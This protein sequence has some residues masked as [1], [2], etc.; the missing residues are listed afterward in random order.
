MKRKKIWD[1]V[2]ILALIIAFVLTISGL[3]NLDRTNAEIDDATTRIKLS[4]VSTGE[5]ENETRWTRHED[6]SWYYIYNDEYNNESIVDSANPIE[7]NRID[8]STLVVNAYE[9]NL[10]DPS[11]FAKGY[12]WL[13]WPEKLQDYFDKNN[14]DINTKLGFVNGL[15]SDS[16]AIL[17]P[18]GDDRRKNKDGTYEQLFAF[19]GRFYV[20]RIDLRRFPFM[21][22]NL[23]IIVAPRDLGDSQYDFS[24]L[25]F[26]PLYDKSGI[27]NYTK[28]RGWKTIDWAISEYKQTLNTNLLE[29]GANQDNHSQVIFS[30]TYQTGAYRSFWKLMLPLLIVMSMV[31]LTFK[32]HPEFQDGRI[33]LLVTLL[34]TL[35]VLQEG[36][37]AELPKL[38][39]LSYLDKIYIFSFAATLVSF[40]GVI[41]GA[42]CMKRIERSDNKFEKKK[43]Q[44]RVVLIDTL[45]P[46]V[47]IMSIVVV[48]VVAWR[49]IPG[50]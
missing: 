4:R 16:E 2:S 21:K 49:T 34:L 38:N 31:V 41:Y 45:F 47:L 32:I 22:M 6:G 13:R 11:Y 36:Y 42:S 29:Y 10:S 26:N 37:Q 1:L 50:S 3:K 7:Y 46:P 9:L 40:L 27:G 25:R 30:I 17:E 48:L 15:V 18:I 28:I 8:I 19:D 35:V 12:V 14:S 39:F 5:S 20:D 44:K 24:N 33:A 43:L 23:E